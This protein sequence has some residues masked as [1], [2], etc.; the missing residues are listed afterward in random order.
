MPVP[1][2]TPEAAAYYSTQSPTSDP[3]AYAGLLADLPRDVGGLARVVRGLMIHRA[4]GGQW[5]VPIADDR[6]RDDAETRYVDDILGL[7]AA[8]DPGPLTGRRAWSD[9]FVGICRDFT[10]LH[11]ALLRH[12]G[13]PAR[14]RS[15]F[16][17]YFSDKGFHWDHVATEYWDAER[18]WLLADAQIT[19]PEHYAYGFDPMDIPRDRFIVAGQAW[20]AIRAGDADPLSFGL[21]LEDTPMLGKRFVAG[22]IRYD[23]SALNKVET[24]LWDVWGAGSGTS[25]ETFMD[26]EFPAELDP[27][28]DRAAAVTAGPDPDFAA[29]RDLFATEDGLRTPQTVRSLAPL[30][31]P[32]TVTL[33]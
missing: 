18:G 32:A 1:R 10:L 29:V 28:Y 19:D 31:G 8:R 7:V 11:V 14:L 23:L 15:G 4:E 3:G 16:A 27:L 13:I 30:R 9:R 26:E 6:M 33:R 22:N 12:F 5:G 2:L 25:A 17:T 20:Q 21:D 24:L